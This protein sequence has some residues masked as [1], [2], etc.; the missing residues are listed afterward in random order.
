M[1]F[2][3]VFFFAKYY[4]DTILILIGILIIVSDYIKEVSETS[5]PLVKLLS[6]VQKQVSDP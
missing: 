6:G 1:F 2:F 4:G 5:D 3:V